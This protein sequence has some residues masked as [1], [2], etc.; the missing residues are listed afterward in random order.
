MAKDGTNRGGAR[1][2]AGKKRQPL[3]D[4]VNNGK[5]ATVIDFPEP[6]ELFGEAVPPVKDYMIA[7]QKDGEQFEAKTIYT[8]VFQWLQRRGCSHLVNIQLIEQYSMSVARWIACENAVS[9][10]GYL[11]KHPTTGMATASPF[12][13]MS[14]NYMKQANQL[15]YQ[16]FQV[17]KENCSASYDD[18]AAPTDLMEALLKQQKA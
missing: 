11:A 3:L 9:K 4:K 12:V 10:Y 16:I 7:Q 8:E 14:Q 13:A 5:Q 2:G 17:V 18:F 6:D 15:W 1:I